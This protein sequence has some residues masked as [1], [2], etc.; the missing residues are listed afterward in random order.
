VRKLIL[1]TADLPAHLDDEARFKA[2]HDTYC[3]WIGPTD[4]RRSSDS[5]FEGRWEFAGLGELLLARFCGATHDIARTPQQISACPHDRYFLSFNLAPAALRFSQDGREAVIAGEQALVFSG[6]E[7]F[8]CVGANAWMSVGVPKQALRR[9]VPNVE[10]LIVSPLDGAL[11]A[12]RHLRQYLGMLIEQEG[13]AEDVALM[14]QVETTVLD[15][16]ALA[17]GANGDAA[18]M[19]A[20]RGLRAVR[21]RAVIAEIRAGYADASFSAHLVAARLGLSERY[22]QQLLQ[23]TG[24]SFSER[25]LELRLLKVRAMLAN[26]R[27]DHLNV[28]EI[29]LACGFNEVSYFN[30]CF[31]RRFAAS[32]TQLRGAEGR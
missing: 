28:S 11:P 10:D 31:R 16:I 1:S 18:A 13:P 27:H 15:L 26:R 20:M 12:M 5:P 24:V 19:A 7:S 6:S 9:L 29:A 25:V 32:P 23:G 4:V 2:W 3:D 14:S 17:L 21:A 30:R 22:I 8:Q